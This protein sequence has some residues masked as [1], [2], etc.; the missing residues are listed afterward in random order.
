M[1]ETA[2][3]TAEQLD[4]K[5][6]AALRALQTPDTNIHLGSA[7]LAYLVER[8]PGRISAVIASYNAGPSAVARWL[9]GEG[10]GRED[11][12]W[13]EEIP[14]AQTRSYAKRVLRSLYIYQSLY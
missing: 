9:D 11:D 4:L 2:Q 1:P 8:F 12:E 13:V 6:G 14:Y 7:Y 5:E 3:S 10:E